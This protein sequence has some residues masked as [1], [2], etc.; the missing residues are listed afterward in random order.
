VVCI[1]VTQYRAVY[2]VGTRELVSST[3]PEVL[4][5]SYLKDIWGNWELLLEGFDA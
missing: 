1:Y 3:M 2:A 4:E 5:R